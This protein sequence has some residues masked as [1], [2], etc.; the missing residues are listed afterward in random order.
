MLSCRAGVTGRGQGEL[1]GAPVVVAKA[2]QEALFAGLLAFW[3]PKG[4]LAHC[5]LR[6]WQCLA[7]SGRPAFIDSGEAGEVTRQAYW[8][9]MGHGAQRE[10]RPSR[11]KAP[12]CSH[13]AGIG[14]FLGWTLWLAV[15]PGPSRQDGNVSDEASVA[16]A[17][18]SEVLRVKSF[19][20]PALATSFL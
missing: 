15:L 8:A 19:H 10:L 2:G 18:P 3:E 1:L 5:P 4:L 7:H 6:S 14:V 17:S 11:G 20:F 16:G 9:S 12:A 13:R